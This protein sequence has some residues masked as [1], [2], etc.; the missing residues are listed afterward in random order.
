[1]RGI[2]LREPGG[3]F[4]DKWAKRNN[5]QPYTHN[6]RIQSSSEAPS[7]LVSTYKGMNFSEGG[8]CLE[9]VNSFLFDPLTKGDSM[10]GR[11]EELLESLSVNSIT[12]ISRVQPDSWCL[13]CRVG[14]NLLQSV[15]QSS[16][17]R[18]YSDKISPGVEPTEPIHSWDMKLQYGNKCSH[19]ILGIR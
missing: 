10:S 18:S 16:R 14:P 4:L 8:R 12:S 1:M 5:S 13:F 11:P 3:S 7:S 6:T 9:S 17:W 19:I 2:G 15:R